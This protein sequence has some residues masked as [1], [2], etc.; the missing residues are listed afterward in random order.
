MRKQKWYI[1][2]RY[3][4]GN[5]GTHIEEIYATKEEVEKME[6]DRCAVVFKKYISALYYLQ[7]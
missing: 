6:S 3:L 2:Q 5:I 7:N 1:I 4:N